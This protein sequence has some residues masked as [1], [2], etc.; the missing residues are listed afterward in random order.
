MDTSFT[1]NIA[2]SSTDLPC[3]A[4]RFCPALSQ[5][6][7]AQWLPLT[8]QGQRYEHRVVLLTRGGGE[9]DTTGGNTGEANR[10]FLGKIHKWKYKKNK[11][12]T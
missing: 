10:Q 7:T 5:L 12:N 6:Y 2:H 4:N 3:L 1:E 9:W 8:G 11:R